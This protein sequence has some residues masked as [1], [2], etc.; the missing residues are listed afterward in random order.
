M[1]L[2]EEHRLFDVTLATDDFEQIQAHTIILSAGSNVLV[3][4]ISQ[5]SHC[6]NANAN[7][8]I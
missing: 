5:S 7:M 1:S 4:I 6:N 3:E 8:F 2:W